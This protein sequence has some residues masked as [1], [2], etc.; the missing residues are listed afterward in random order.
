MFWPWVSFCVCPE[1]YIDCFILALDP[2]NKLDFYRE[3]DNPDEFNQAKAML[4]NA[5]S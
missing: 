4:L 3:N 1:C 5:V 2:G